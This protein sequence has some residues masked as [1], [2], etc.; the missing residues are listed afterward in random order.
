MHFTQRQKILLPV[1]T[2]L[3]AGTNS[4]CTTRRKARSYRV[5]KTL[6]AQATDISTAR[7]RSRLEN[8]RTRRQPPGARP[9]LTFQLSPSD[10]HSAHNDDCFLNHL[11]D[12]IKLFTRIA[13]I[14][15]ELRGLSQQHQDHQADIVRLTAKVEVHAEGNRVGTPLGSLDSV[16]SSYQADCQ[17][18]RAL[19]NE[20]YDREVDLR[21]EVERLRVYT[22]ATQDHL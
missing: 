5:E 18:L 20:I 19:Q 2:C 4:L 6:N 10:H 8:Q 15:D 13:D 17:R 14:N 11:C 22:V 3:L 1:L 16:I 12:L 7:R 9:W 21:R